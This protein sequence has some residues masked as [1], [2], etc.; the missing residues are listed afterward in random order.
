MSIRL[1]DNHQ[2]NM[3]RKINKKKYAI[4]GI[5]QGGANL[6]STGIN[7]TVGGSTATTEAEAKSQTASNMLS[8]AAS[9]ASIGMAAGPIGAAVGAVVGAIP[10]IIGKKGKVTPNGFFEDPSVTYSTGL[11]R[12]NKGIKRAYNAAKQ[13]VAGNR[14]AN[15]QGQDLAQ[16][17]DETY[18]TDVMTLAQGG[19]SPSLAYVDDGELIQTPDGQVNKVPEKGQPTDSN[20]VSLPEGSKILSDKVKYPG[21]KKTFAQVG[22]EMMTKKK[23]KNKDRFAKNSAKL[24]EMNNK[25]I[26]DQLFEMQEGLKKNKDFDATHFAKGGTKLGYKN[27]NG[28]QNRDT[29]RLPLDASIESIDRLIDTTGRTINPNFIYNTTSKVASKAPAPT[30]TGVDVDPGSIV[31]TLRSTSSPAQ[32]T[33]TPGGFNASGILG[34]V[35][36]TI[37]SLAPIIS[38]LATGDAETVNTN[39]NPYAGT[40]A[41]TMRRRR[42]NITPAIEDLNRSRAISNYN[43]SRVNP[44]TGTNIAFRL[45]SALG[46]NRA[47]ADLRAQE[48]NVNNQYAAD[49]ASTLNNLGQQYVGATN[50]SAEQNAQNRAAARNTRRAGLSQLSQWVQNRELMRNQ[51]TRDDAM[52]DLYKPFLESGYSSDVLQNVYNTYVKGGNRYGR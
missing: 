45:Q 40:I 17:F 42:F 16:E 34:N 4:G 7:S 19:Y 18:D 32:T 6:L 30:L 15:T 21:T 46:Q 10:G 1:T 35:T 5:V 37:G 38:N 27:Y 31:S 29:T 9:G 22:E 3:K 8:G 52:L 51:R 25:L 39:Y 14:I 49:Y 48:S 23:S 20:L 11:F 47:I 44:N 41:S 13:R 12:S 2:Y 50:L 33:S 43:A 28:I 24:N 26:H 36:S